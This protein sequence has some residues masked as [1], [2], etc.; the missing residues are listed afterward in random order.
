MSIHNI[1]ISREIRKILCG[2]PLLSAAM[3]VQIFI[4]NSPSF[5]IYFRMHYF[6]RI[7]PLWIPSILLIAQ[8]VIGHLSVSTPQTSL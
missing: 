2:Y 6:T 7:V 1:C 5:I 8:H 3:V 4:I